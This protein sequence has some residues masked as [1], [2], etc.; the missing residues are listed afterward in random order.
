MDQAIDLFGCRAGDDVRPD[1]IQQRRVGAPGGPH[2]VALGMIQKDGL[3]LFQHR[4]HW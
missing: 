1:I 3:A 4:G 2:Q